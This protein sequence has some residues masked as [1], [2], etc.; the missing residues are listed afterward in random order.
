MTREEILAL[1]RLARIRVSDAEADNLQKEIDAILGYVSTIND[2]VT[3]AGTMR[4][5]PMVNVFRAD[6]VT[7]EPDQY[8]EALLAAM[9]ERRGRFM[10]VK[11]ILG[12][13][14]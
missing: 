14:D 6:V 2:L 13:T 8:T 12:G 7:N 5:T 10:Q 3:D 1:G 11:K 4:T 9:P